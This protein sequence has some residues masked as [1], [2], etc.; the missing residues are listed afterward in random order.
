MAQPKGQRPAS[1][2]DMNRS[3]IYR[4][5][6][7]K[8]SASLVEVAK[9]LRLNEHTIS[10]IIDEM[11]ASG[12]VEEAGHQALD[13]AG[14]N[15]MTISFNSNHK[16]SIGAHLTSTDIHWTATDLYA[17]PLSSFSVPLADCRPDQ[18][19]AALLQGIDQLAD[20]FPMSQCLGVSIAVPGLIDPSSGSVIR[21]GHLGW[22]DVPFLSFLKKH[23]TL[24]LKLDN[25][26]KLASLGELWHGSGQSAD[27]FI[28]CY[29]GNDVGCSLFVNGSIVRGARNDAGELGHIIVNSTGPMCRCGN[30]GCLEAWVSLPSILG[31][32][33]RGSAS[34]AGAVSL[35]WTLSELEAGNARVARE[36]EQAGQY[37]GHALSYAVN[38]LNPELIICD[39]PLM[40]A[41]S[42][43]FPI[44]EEQLKRRCISTATEPLV[45]S[46]SELFPYAGSI[47]AAASV[48]QAWEE[49]SVTT[50]RS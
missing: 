9:E 14:R 43:L 20:E 19:A 24:Q 1:A 33:S 34:T 23:T 17:R 15:S 18:A 31:R 21:S 48:I 11:L 10:S 22:N 46:R 5:I 36:F 8:R 35:E 13:T 42:C 38:L 39:G 30:S 12:L 7:Q 40:R 29:F 2:K 6:K 16:W 3:L 4:L 27:N 32:I 45:L 41:S 28:Y 37:I 50:A 44:I 25:S 47:G 26:V 49:H